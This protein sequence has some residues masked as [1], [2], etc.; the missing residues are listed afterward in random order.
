MR[1]AHPLAWLG[2]VFLALPVAVHMLV[3]HRARIQ[4]LPTLRFLRGESPV[5]M[6]R[7]RPD[8]PRLLL[9]RMAI[10][11][12][13]VAALAGPYLF[14]ADPPVGPTRPGSE[15]PNRVVLVDESWS[16]LRPV[17]DSD[18]ANPESAQD[19]ARALAVEAAAEARMSTVVAV[20]A[21]LPLAA[22]LEGAAAWL[23]RLAGSGE[24]VF[25][26]D[27]QR[28][29]LETARGA[30][31]PGGPGL[32]PI[33]VEVAAAGSAEGAARWSLPLRGESAQV[34]VAEVDDAVRLTWSRVE[35]TSGPEVEFVNDPGDENRVSEL[36][37]VAE[38]VG[39]LTPA[40]AVPVRVIF[41]GAPEGPA[42][43][44]AALSPDA[45]SLLLRLASDRTLAAAAAEESGAADTPAEVSA[46]ALIVARDRA[47]QPL[48]LA[49]A[50]PPSGL[51][52]RSSVPPGSLTAA[53]L[54]VALGRASHPGPPGTELEPRF[55]GAEERA[56][57][58]RMPGAV[59]PESADLT[60]TPVAR[61]GWML[62]LVLLV[63]ESLYRRRIH[64]QRN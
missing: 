62:V 60:R 14:P 41:P 32:V 18:P 11:G 56:S 38:N 2:L 55:D 42:P 58:A 17:A 64:A 19:R 34:E 3:R 43:E 6:R 26:S 52:I 21:D 28:G 59:E 44:S 30:V 48:L 5:A 49:G 54:L 13:A 4:R 33:A 23:E 46:G 51:W 53:A 20:G 15:Q 22:A 16:M 39:A 12:L 40:A 63:G 47:G 50:A 57:W 9:L 27:F 36:R 25:I 7:S 29:T 35:G 45:A 24:I 37:R 10:I 8:E 61:W 1:F 31:L